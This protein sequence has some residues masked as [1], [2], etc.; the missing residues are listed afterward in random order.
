MF[1]K[2]KAPSIEKPT[3]GS[4]TLISSGT[5]LNGDVVSDNDLRIDGTI[6]GNVQCSAKI[7]IGTTGFVD[8]HI[9]GQQA[10]ITGKVLGNIVVSEILQLRGQCNVTGNITAAKLQ[11]EPTATFNGQCQMG[12][13]ANIVKMS[14]DVQPAAEAK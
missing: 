1:N 4:A 2:E 13:V 14:S 7:I 3:S 8:G 9:Q 6:N 5:T 10:D 12:T 11:I